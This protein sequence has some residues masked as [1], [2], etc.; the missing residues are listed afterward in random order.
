MPRGGAGRTPRC[1]RRSRAGT[2][3]ARRT[4]VGRGG[5]QGGGGH[6]AASCSVDGRRI[7]SDVRIRR[8]AG[9]GGL[10][11]LNERGVRDPAT[12]ANRQI[13]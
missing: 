5:R 1:Y 4:E 7:V 12:T 8:L 6:R 9:S 2:A 11:A 3:M 13:G 10:T